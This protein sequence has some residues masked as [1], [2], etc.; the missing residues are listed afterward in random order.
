[1]SAITLTVGSRKNG[2]IT[3]VSGSG[4][5]SMSDTLIFCQPRID[6]PSNPTPSSKVPTSQVSI[7]KEQCCQVPRR[8]VNFRSTMRALCFLAK[9][10]NSLGV[11]EAFL[12]VVVIGD[13]SRPS[14]SSAS[15]P[16]A[17]GGH[18]VPRA[19]RADEA[20]LEGFDQP[21]TSRT[22]ASTAP[23]REIGGKYC[24][25]RGIL[26]ILAHEWA[27]T[28]T[29]ARSGAR[30]ERQRDRKAPAPSDHALVSFPAASLHEQH[31]PIA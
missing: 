12:L 9:S 23:R 16:G 28:E 27:R 14:T 5:A 1:M 21:D 17:V 3:V 10:K 8:S 25:G 15:G 20:R 11:M 2:S 30:P 19:L 24:R 13:A 6:D 7:G 18:L 26:E 31:L 29:Y 22:T 4:M